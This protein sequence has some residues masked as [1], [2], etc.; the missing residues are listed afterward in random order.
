MLELLPGGSLR[1]LN[2]VYQ[3]CWRFLPRRG[4]DDDDILLWVFIPFVLSRRLDDVLRELSC[5]ILHD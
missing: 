2:R 3:V 1:C 4:L 5:W